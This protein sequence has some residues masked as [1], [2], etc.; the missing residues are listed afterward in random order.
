MLA[1]FNIHSKCFI[2]FSFP[3]A[4]LVV[5]TFNSPP[6]LDVVSL[7]VAARGVQLHGHVKW[8]LIHI[9]HWIKKLAKKVTKDERSNT[10]SKESHFYLP[11]FLPH[12]FYYYIVTRK[13]ATKR[14]AHILYT[15]TLE[16]RWPH[17]SDCM[18]ERI[19]F[20]FFRW[21]QLGQC[22]IE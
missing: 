8:F 10:N 11:A 18:H 9:I 19:F 16:K 6:S 4:W 21:F 22:C 12:R 13:K 2:C 14:R 20:S 5:F 3:L 17:R 15:Q 1:F 7:V